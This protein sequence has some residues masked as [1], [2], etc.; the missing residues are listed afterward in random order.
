MPKGTENEPTS[1]NTQ[2]NTKRIHVVLKGK[3]IPYPSIMQTESDVLAS[4]SQLS[5]TGTKIAVITSAP[6]VSGLPRSEIPTASG[7]LASAST[8]SLVSSSTGSSS[9]LQNSPMLVDESNCVLG[10]PAHS[11]PA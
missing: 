10:I 8:L 6:V 9:P 5:P 7:D 2:S 4:N 11:K 3:E 1:T